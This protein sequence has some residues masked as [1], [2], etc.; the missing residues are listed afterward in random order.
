VRSTKGRIRATHANAGAFSTAR[1]M[2]VAGALCLHEHPGGAIIAVLQSALAWAS[3]A[4]GATPW[5]CSLCRACIGQ[6]ELQWLAMVWSG[7]DTGVPTMAATTAT[8]SGRVHLSE[9]HAMFSTHTHAS[10]GCQRGESPH[11]VP[12]STMVG[13]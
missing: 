11:P 9:R 7:P 4:A 2:G 10:S 8:A 6:S 1:S 12:P 3:A 13:A 5:Q